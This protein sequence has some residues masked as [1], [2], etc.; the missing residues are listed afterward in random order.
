MTGILSK[1]KEK[2][3]TKVVT[4]SSPSSIG[5]RGSSSSSSSGN[6]NSKNS[7]DRI[8][9]PEPCQQHPDGEPEEDDSEPAL[10]A[11]NLARANKN[12]RKLQ[13]DPGLAHD[14]KTY[15]GVLASTGRMSH[16]DSTAGAGENLY[17]ATTA[18]AGLEDAVQ[19][20]LDEERKYG[21]E[22]VGEGNLEDWGHYS[23]CLWA[24]TTHVGM[25][26]ATSGKK[27]YIVARYS[28]RGNVEGGKPY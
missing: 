24:S 25:G 8:I 16:S 27:T 7:P 1:T 26:K 9:P 3:T 6:G 2:L 4:S 14:A 19:S 13:W 18:E 10:Q 5:S 12:V 15:A 23:Q 21:G 28:P 20:W 17:E 11:H 22:K